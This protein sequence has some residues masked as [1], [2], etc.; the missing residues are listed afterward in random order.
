MA[1][2]GLRGG[3]LEIANG[4]TGGGPAAD[5]GANVEADTKVEAEA[6]VEMEALAQAKADF[7]LRLAEAEVKE[8]GNLPAW[9]FP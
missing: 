9:P 6:K 3:V 1:S 5:A 4:D 7:S 8:A 2:A